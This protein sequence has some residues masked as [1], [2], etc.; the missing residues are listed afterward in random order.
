MTMTEAI[1]LIV[2]IVLMIGMLVIAW[3]GVV[4]LGGDD[5]EE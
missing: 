4:W 1:W 2:C 5:Y 3:T